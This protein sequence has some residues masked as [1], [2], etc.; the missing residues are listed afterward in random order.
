MDIDLYI[1]SV[2]SGFFT[3][4]DIEKRIQEF[5]KL[6]EEAIKD[7]NDDE[8]IVYA[9][10]KYEKNSEKMVYANLMTE[11][12]TYQEYVGICK[13][14]KDYRRYFFIKKDKENTNEKN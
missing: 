9:V 6:A 4:K 13:S 3:I 1:D 14:D 10:F 7:A 11:K 8:I 5:R 12:I 2:Y